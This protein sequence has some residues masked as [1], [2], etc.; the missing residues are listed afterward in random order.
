MTATPASLHLRAVADRIVD[1][2]LLRIPLRAA[3]LVGSAARGDSDLFSDVDLIL[4]VD[5]LPTDVT[6]IEIRTA[7]GG[8]QPRSRERTA[9]ACG[10]EFVLDG[11]R[12]EL[13]FILVARIESHLDHVLDRVDE[14][15]S[16]LQKAF[17][18]VL[19][20][21]PLHGAELIEKWRNRLRHYPESLRRAM[22]EKHW[23]FVPLW[24]HTDSMAARDCELWRREA[25]LEASFNLLAVLSGL[26]RLYFSRFQLTRLRNLT[27]Q[28]SLSPPNLAE[29][30]ESLFELPPAQAADELGQLVTE[31][32]E[33]VAV[34]LPDL[35]LPM[36]FP[37]GTRQRP[38]RIGEA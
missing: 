28:M 27:R 14:I 2:A 21:L 1:A 10:E 26:N 3:L 22:I 12:I 17:T 20:G 38:W 33:L 9:H 16:P 15:D 23:T 29:R 36:R 5:E 19:E 34:E 24:Y 37:P 7:V 13:P 30:L 18:G 4:Y 11:I 31:T 32:R 6:L 35:D 8:S 25:L